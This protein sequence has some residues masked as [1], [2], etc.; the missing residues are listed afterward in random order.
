MWASSRRDDREKESGLVFAPND[1]CEP[2]EKT[3][4][5]SKRRTKPA[6]LLGSAAAALF[7][8]AVFWRAL[9]YS[10]PGDAAA[11]TEERTRENLRPTAQLLSDNSYGLP[12]AILVPEDE[13]W[14]L[15]LAAPL[16]SKLEGEGGKPLVLA[17]SAESPGEVARLLIRPELD[18]RLLLVPEASPEALA[19]IGEFVVDKVE[20]GYDPT[21]AAIG[22]ANRFWRVSDTVILASS[23]NPCALILG[24]TLASHLKVPFVPVGIPYEDKILSENLGDLG[25]KKALLIT[26]STDN[27]PPWAKALRQEVEVLDPEGVQRRIIDRLGAKNVRNI[28]LTRLPCGTTGE[29]WSSWMAAY[30]SLLRGSPVVL[31]DSF[32]AEE[33]EAKVGRLIETY[34]LSPRSVTI[35]ADYESI[36]V[37][38]IKDEV[39]LGD[40]VVDIEPCSGGRKD[41]AATMGVGRIPCSRLSEVSTLIGR[42]VIRD[43]ISVQTP[44]RVLMVANP[45]TDYAPLPLCE[46]VSRMTAEEFKNFGLVVDEFYGT[47]PGDPEIP[48]EEDEL[49]LVPVKNPNILAETGM[50]DFFDMPQRDPAIIA[51]SEKAHIIIYEG[52]RYDQ[53][54]FEASSPAIETGVYSEFD[55]FLPAGNEESYDDRSR[56]QW[57]PET[58]PRERDNLWNRIFGFWVEVRHVRQ[59]ADRTPPSDSPSC[60]V[61]TMEP[62]PTVTQTLKG[63]PLVILQSCY[64]LEDGLDWR[65]FDADGVALLV[66]TTSVHSASGSAFVKAFCDGVLYRGDT[67]GEALRDARNYFLCLAELKE[68]RG[69]KELAKV[70]RVAL[71][72]RLLG[73]PELRIPGAPLPKPKHQPVSAK[74]I[75]TDS[76]QISI[77]A[78]RLPVARTAEYFMRMFPGSEAAGIV[79]RSKRRVERRVTPIYFFRLSAPEHF[80]DRKYKDVE[81]DG[82]RD[83]RSIFISDPWRRFVYVLYLP[84]KERKR[85]NFTLHFIR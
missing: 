52:H 66:S 2:V 23:N 7:A 82:D 70:Y 14:L 1:S 55:D 63:L 83:E 62:T 37:I 69:H 4:A 59:R 16:A 26:D 41:T 53:A 20:T 84:K 51:A 25:A 81:R 18:R 24:S 48:T 56:P 28:I 38:P 13:E 9:C 32:D 19:A 43:R 71:S 12:K 74:F 67:I 44:E 73:D 42:S 77:P 80:Y 45:R 35:L 11:P 64:S 58:P 22:L 76:L 5:T 57:E 34:S 49:K 72:F 61:E 6:F 54:I 46:T 47:P 15:M 27:V 36:G 85:E 33:A 31:C 40:Y 65:I 10:A 75:D 78:R 39:Y 29:G 21:D 8:A 79:K 17:I 3:A 60:T 50:D 30:L 68:R